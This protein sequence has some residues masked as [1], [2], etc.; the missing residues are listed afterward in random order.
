MRELSTDIKIFK[1]IVFSFLV[2]L[3]AVL[4][5]TVGFNIRFHT[6]PDA[7]F[8][9]VSLVEA[10]P[11]AV[12]GGPTISETKKVEKKAAQENA[13]VAKVV[14]PDKRPITKQVPLA[15]REIDLPTP[16]ENPLETK[17]LLEEALNSIR[18]RV[19]EEEK[20]RAHLREA[21]EKISQKASQQK[22]LSEGPQGA[23][24]GGVGLGQGKG[25]LAIDIYKAQITNVIWSNW[26]FPADLYSESK[27]LSLEAIVRLSVERSGKI[28]EYEIIKRSNDPTFDSSI[29]R[30]IERSNPLP[31][32]PETFDSLKQEID[33]IFNVKDLIKKG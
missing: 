8:M 2:H 14:E 32:L 9:E 5:L 27:L 16:K 15:K 11:S 6:S 22:G 24:S 10:P 29:L 12:E 21:L 4:S 31:P 20:Q 30:A 18:D 25:G 33:V 17:K 28:V 26:N 1:A 13:N 3:M 19:K 7:R 23:S